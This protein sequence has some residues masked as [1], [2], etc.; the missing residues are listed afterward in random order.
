MDL[1]RTD[2]EVD[3]VEGAR[4]GELLDDAAHLEDGAV[5][6]GG[7]RSVGLSVVGDHAANL[8]ALLTTVKQKLP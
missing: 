6:R 8:G 1:A 4:T 2:V 5:G 7:A 3:A